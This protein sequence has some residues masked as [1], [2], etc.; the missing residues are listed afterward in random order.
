MRLNFGRSYLEL[1][2]WVICLLLF[3]LIGYLFNI[4][5]GGELSG[6]RSFYLQK[7]RIAKEV[8][9][10]KRFIIIG[11]SGTHFGIDA[12]IVE[13]ETKTSSLHMGVHGGLG[14]NVILAL[15]VDRVREG[16]IVVLIPEYGILESPNGTDRMAGSFSIAIGHPFMSGLPINQIIEDGYRVGTPGLQS[17]CKSIL[18]LITRG[19]RYY[20]DELTSHGDSLYLK[21]QRQNTPESLQNAQISDHAYK[22]IKAFKDKLKLKGADLVIVLPWVYTTKDQQTVRQI[23]GI[24]RRLEQVAPTVYDISSLN[25]QTDPRLFSD[26]NYHLSYKGRRLRSLALAQQLNHINSKINR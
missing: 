9:D 20:S 12:Q 11:G 1:S 23:R 10:S 2:S 6:A 5:R 26:T 19:E 8:K 14:L 17:I 3:W 21:S 13:V 4:C 16:D 25:L 7:I 18:A 22:H 24:T 15:Y